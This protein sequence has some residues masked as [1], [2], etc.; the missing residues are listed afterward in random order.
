MTVTRRTASAAALLLLAAAAAVLLLRA[1]RSGAQRSFPSVIALPNGWQPE[2]IASGPGNIL[3]VGSIPTGR[4]LRVDARTGRR[5]VVVP[6]R[7]GRAAIGLKE[8]AGLLFVAGGPTGRGFVYR[9]S[10]G[11]TVANVRLTAAPTFINDVTVTRSAAWFTDSQRQQLYRLPLGAGGRPSGGAQT[12]PITGDLQYDDDPETFEANGIAAT[13]DGRSLLVVQ[14]RT[15]GLFLV[16][17]SGASTRVQ[18]TGGDG[19]GLVNGDGLL[20]AGRTLYAVQNQLNRVAV[21]E[22]EA[23]FARGR[24]RRYLRDS[25]F[26]VPTTVAR[27]GSSLYLPN[28]RFG[29]DPGPSTEYDVVRVRAR[30]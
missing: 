8:R 24:I 3:Y 10:T 7:S 23:G 4:V 18:I 16:D 30:R 9:A 20:L 12:V 1:D 17:P 26:D 27:K 21:V 25:D 5:R 28:A 14:S 6:R 22:L 29:T 13:G 11:A 19:R 2:G 15:G